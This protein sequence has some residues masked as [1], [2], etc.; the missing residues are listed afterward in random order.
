MLYDVTQ[1]VQA[2]ERDAEPLR[3]ETQ[4][5]NVLRD[6]KRVRASFNYSCKVLRLAPCHVGQSARTT[7]APWFRNQPIK[8]GIDSLTSQGESL[9]PPP[10]PGRPQSQLNLEEIL[11]H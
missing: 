3:H 8:G 2:E 10:P 11:A 1:H 6:V 9:F 5:P 4:R 7:A